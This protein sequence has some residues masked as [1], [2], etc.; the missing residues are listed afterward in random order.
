MS[1]IE[2]IKRD[3]AQFIW[4]PMAHPGAMKKTAPDI[5]ARG[6]AAG[7]GTWTATR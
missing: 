1:D 3:N 7:S 4:H 6:E 5:I 2:R